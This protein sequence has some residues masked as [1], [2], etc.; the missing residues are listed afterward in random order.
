VKDYYA[1]LGISRE[2]HAREIKRAYKKSV[3]KW[4]PDLHPDDPA[5]RMKMQ[6]INEAY[7]VLGNSAKRQAYDRW[8]QD[9]R[10]VTAAREH[11]PE[12]PASAF[13]SY[14]MK[15]NAALRRK[16]GKP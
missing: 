15:M 7:E 16:S 12:P 3:K 6:E 1:V 10:I 8:T 13:Q 2:A 14:F 4:H 11:F 5:G 9:G